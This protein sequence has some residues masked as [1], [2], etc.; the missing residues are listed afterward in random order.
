MNRDDRI[1]IS[2]VRHD[3]SY[4]MQPH[5]HRLNELY[6]LRDGKSNIFVETKLFKLKPGNL[7]LLR[8]GTIHKTKSTE[9]GGHTRTVLMF[10][11]SVISDFFE[12]DDKL[13]SL[14]EISSK[15]FYIPEFIRFDLINLFERISKEINS[16]DCL[17]DILVNGF[18]R[19]ILVYILR[20]DKNEL[21]DAVEQDNALD[22]VIQTAVSYICENFSRHITLNSTSEYVN[23]SPTY[24]SK[25]FKKDTGFGFKEYLNR[26]RLREAAKLLKTEKHCSIIEIA[27][28]CGFGDSNYFATVFKAEYGISPNR[29]RNMKEI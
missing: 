8:P 28:Q 20:L 23:M 24:F 25:K 13:I 4:K 7:I 6:F 16:R 27:E 26:I 5:F 29:Y 21:C 9:L 17:S 1:T 19:E 11:D 3:R 12:F 2:T 14:D 18:I 22:E 15:L 10:P